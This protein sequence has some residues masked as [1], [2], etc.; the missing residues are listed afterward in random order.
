MKIRKFFCLLPAAALLLS[1]TACVSKENGSKESSRPPASVVSDASAVP[2]ATA[3]SALTPEQMKQIANGLLDH[4]VTE[5]YEKIGY[6][7]SSSY[8]SSCNG[9]GED[10][11]LYYDGFTVYTYKEE[12]KGEVITF[13]Y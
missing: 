13:V 8:S 7:L 2:S 12:G 6:P 10:G 4:S 11:E 9:P 1:L 5:L 3:S